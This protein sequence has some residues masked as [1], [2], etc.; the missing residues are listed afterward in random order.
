L[1]GVE[2][3]AGDFVEGEGGDKKIKKKEVNYAKI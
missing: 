3:V 2:G 1:V